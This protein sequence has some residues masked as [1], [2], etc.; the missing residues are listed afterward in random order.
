LTDNGFLALFFGVMGFL[1]LVYGLYRLLAR[2]LPEPDSGE[3][4]GRG[5]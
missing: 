1:Q 4:D 5:E 2:R 3:T